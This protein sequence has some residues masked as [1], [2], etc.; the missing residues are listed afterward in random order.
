M[1]KGVWG[2]ED[3]VGLL[4]GESGKA[5]AFL[6]VVLIAM[7]DSRREPGTLVRGAGGAPIDADSEGRSI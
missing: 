1:R 6:G 2:L 5:A 3:F 7:M 4:D